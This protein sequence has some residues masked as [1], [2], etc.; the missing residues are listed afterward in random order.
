MTVRP[1]KIP[2]RWTPPEC[3][4]S[5][6]RFSEKSDV[7]SFGVVVCEIF[8]D[9]TRPYRNIGSN[10]EVFTRIL[11]GYRMPCPATCPSQIYDELIA[12]CWDVDVNERPTFKTLS[13]RVGEFLANVTV[14]VSENINAASVSGEAD[15]SQAYIAES[16]RKA[17]DYIH[18]IPNDAS[19][20]GD[21]R[22]SLNEDYLPPLPEPVAQTKSQELLSNL[23]NLLANASS[24]SETTRILR[25]KLILVGEGRAGKTAT[26]KSLLWQPFEPHEKSTI[27]CAS[28]EA[29]LDA[30]AAV[31]WE[32]VTYGSELQR[33]LLAH[34]RRKDE[35]GVALT[36]LITYSSDESATSG[37]NLP[38]D[39]AQ[40]LLS[41]KLDNVVINN[42]N[43][44]SNP[45]HLRPTNTSTSNLSVQNRF[46]K[47]QE[48]PRTADRLNR[49]SAVLQQ[50]TSADA[51]DAANDNDD[52]DDD[53]DDG[54]G[55]GGGGGGDDDDGGG[56]ENPDEGADN[57][58]VDDNNS[59]SGSDE[60]GYSGHALESVNG[61]VA[62]A[63]PSTIFVADRSEVA[64]S[65]A[66][67]A[68]SSPAT[69]LSSNTDEDV[70]ITVT[71]VDDI[72]EI[73]QQS[74][75]TVG[76]E[77]KQPTFSPVLVAANDSPAVAQRRSKGDIH[78]NKLVE[79]SSEPPPVPPRT[80]D[81]GIILSNVNKLAPTSS[82]DKAVR[83]DERISNT[84][85]SSNLNLVKDL[86]AS[87]RQTHPKTATQDDVASTELFIRDD[88]VD[89]SRNNEVHDL[90]EP[91]GLKIALQ[92]ARL[93][94]ESK[95]GTAEDFQDHVLYSIWD[96]AGQSVFY[97]ML[98]ILMTRLVHSL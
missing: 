55:G 62:A 8:D 48:H 47:D 51:A 84:S 76:H 56:G 21:D 19:Q 49:L 92:K 38:H 13:Q 9:G 33:I 54:G 68:T 82:V 67:A 52:D 14:F 16:A 69:F 88:A 20:S 50:E 60:D 29:R 25:S 53:N 77:N 34:L 23:R 63:E 85:I 3:F 75:E 18:L 37:A 44:H 27:C 81:R 4:Q 87:P 43:S 83:G 73:A 64:E 5:P 26:C 93:A 94:L 45:D 32:S 10:Q 95:L 96:F 61:A 98:D 17:H 90:D 12:C 97:D 78:K 91:I 41:P 59:G 31:A 86:C 30:H 2:V 74:S 65:V 79:R 70:A 15:A 1:M 72:G 24:Y 35:K 7:W 80:K 71:T 42:P 6:R 28:H 40:E 39:V 58:S 66:H 46:V 89:T 57:N 36:K 11:A 22:A